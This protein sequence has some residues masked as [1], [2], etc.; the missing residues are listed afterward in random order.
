MVRLQKG[1][2]AGWEVKFSRTHGDAYYRDTTTNAVLW[3]RPA[4]AL[5]LE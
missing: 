2:P 5:P 4:G 3:E 1:L